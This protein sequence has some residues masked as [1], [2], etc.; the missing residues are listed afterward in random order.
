MGV[1]AAGV[2]ITAA[3]SERKRWSTLNRLSADM[4]QRNE[5]FKAFERALEDCDKTGYAIVRNL[6]Q[7][8]VGGISVP[9]LWQGSLAALTM[10][11]STG[12][13]NEQRMRNDLVPILLKAAHEIGA[14]PVGAAPVGAVPS[15]ANLSSG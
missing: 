13:I 10:P 11:I 12:S 5:D 4:E 6:W 7:E 14:A 8:G 3:L 2:A 15:G 9:L 1:S